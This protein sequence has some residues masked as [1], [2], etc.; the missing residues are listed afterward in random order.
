MSSDWL[1][2][3]AA[4]STNMS[5][6]IIYKSAH[7]VH[8][9]THSCIKSH[10][11]SH[12]CKSLLWLSAN[13]VLADDL[14]WWKLNPVCSLWIFAHCVASLCKW[15]WAGVCVCERVC[16]APS[17]PFQFIGY[18]CHSVVFT[19]TVSPSILRFHLYIFVHVK[20]FMALGLF[21]P[22]FLLF[23]TY[24]GNANQDL[25]WETFKP[26]GLAWSIFLR[27]TVL[28]LCKQN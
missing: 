11:M 18:R 10:F 24:L 5:T 6:Y 14:V 16:V 8:L 3:L 12:N 19:E 27:E 15:K 7:I 17:L 20:V 21:P 25:L 26:T 13:V 22:P 1:S 2:R 9:T 28:Y 4:L 23:F